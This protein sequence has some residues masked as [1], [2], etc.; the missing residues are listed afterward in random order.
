MCIVIIMQLTIVLQIN[1]FCLSMF[2]SPVGWYI[3]FCTLL[4]G[5]TDLE[6]TKK[7]GNNNFIRK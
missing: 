3:R 7:Q 5:I 1:M 6:N 4:Y 2:T